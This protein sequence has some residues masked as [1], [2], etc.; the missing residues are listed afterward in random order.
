MFLFVPVCALIFSC[1]KEE[2]ELVAENQTSTQLVSTERIDLNEPERPGENAGGDR[3]YIA[4]DK[5]HCA[6]P[7]ES[8]NNITGIQCDAGTADDC[9]TDD[10]T[11]C[12][13]STAF[14]NLVS[15]YLTPAEADLF[16]GKTYD[17]QFVYDNWDFFLG[18][19]NMQELNHPDSIIQNL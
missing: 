5:Y 13:E 2:K 10:Y 12:K 1:E 11:R 16:W 17:R 15:L 19:Y 8:G 9:W 7:G 14:N 3:E 18:G 6:L 4:Y